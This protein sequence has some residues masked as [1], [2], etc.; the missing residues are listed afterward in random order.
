MAYGVRSNL[1]TKMDA[2]PPE[3]LSIKEGGARVRCMMD[4]FALTPATGKVAL[5]R[6][7]TNAVIVDIKMWWD[8]L[9]TNILANVGIYNTDGTPILFQYFANNFHMHDT[10]GSHAGSHSGPEQ[11]S[12]HAHMRVEQN[13]GLHRSLNQE[14][15][16]LA[17]M[18]SDPGGNLD[19]ALDWNTATDP[20]EGILTFVV[21]YLID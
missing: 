20:V 9:G 16:Q 1:I 19:I 21:Y 7:P 18:S 8:D 3:M 14:F 2:D 13:A 12:H 4:S 5:C 17:G 11:E 15:W 10:G 6:L